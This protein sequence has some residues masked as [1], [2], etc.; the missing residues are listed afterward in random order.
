MDENGEEC[1]RI[2]ILQREN[3][4]C[5]RSASTTAAGCAPRQA[6]SLIDAS[7]GKSP[8]QPR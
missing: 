5:G 6:T 3:A 1:R 7:S 8:R 2:R 4:G